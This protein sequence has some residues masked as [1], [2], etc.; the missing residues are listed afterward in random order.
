MHEEIPQKEMHEAI[1]YT[2]LSVSRSNGDEVRQTKTEKR[3][4][5][6]S[7]TQKNVEHT[8]RLEGQS[9][10]MWKTDWSLKHKTLHFTKS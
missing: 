4:T 7:A 6:Q 1:E 8:G 2:A 10:K 3:A 9:A 5:V